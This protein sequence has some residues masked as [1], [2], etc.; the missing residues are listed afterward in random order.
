MTGEPIPDETARVVVERYVNPRKAEW[1]EAEYVV[2]NPPFLGKLYVASE[3]GDGYAAALRNAYEGTV[4][5]GSD[6]VL[7]WWQK[8]A[9]LVRGGLLQRFGLVTTNSVTQTMNRRILAN[10]LAADPPMHLAYAV[11]D[12]PW[13]EAEGGA[14]V[15]IAM[16][17]GAPGE[18]SGRLAVV[19]AEGAP[20]GFD[21]A[22]PVVLRER[23][24][25]IQE[26][27]T[28]G[29]DV[30][31]AGPLAANAALASMGPMLGSRGFTVEGGERDRLVR[32]DGDDAV[33]RIRPLRNGKDLVAS[34]RGLYVIDM[35]GL[36]ESELRTRFPATYQWLLGR[37]YPERAQ[38][39]DAKL[40]EQWWLFR[41]ANSLWRSMLQG[42]PRHIVTVETAKHRVFFFL[43]SD[44]IGEHGTISFG[45]DRAEYL[46]ILSSRPHVVWALATGGTL[47]DRPRYNKSVCFDPFP[48]PT[49]DAAQT[50]RI[51]SL[52]E[53][54]DAH[55]KRQQALHPG[56]TITGMY[57]VL[58][59]LRSGEALTA[60]EKVIHEEGLVSVLKQIH[61]DLDA[62]VFEAYGWPSTL[63]DEEILERLVALNAERAEEEKR[64][65]VRWLRPEFQNP[66]GTKAATQ[67]ALPAGDDE[68]EEPAAK[69]AAPLAWPKALPERIAAVRDLMARAPSPRS[70]A[71]VASAFAKAK[72]KDVEAVLDSLASLGLLV[73]FDAPDGRHWQ[74]ASA[75][76]A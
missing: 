24:G 22:I 15:R 5:D 34:P 58:E 37:V 68:D 25:R 72:P 40:R 70:L 31:S 29:P 45:L 54:L 64:G 48:F 21:D 65:L 39:R 17:V 49:T 2:G 13:V 62:A 4:P 50:A 7:Y 26:N 10:A 32:S 66:G 20:E 74:A 52:G 55:R 23:I 51:R 69:P 30:P 28:I 57:N 53:A 14:A 16:T 36:D 6:L 1:P 11:P 76:R 12:H 59:K 33:A 63:T 75:P 18:G 44:V 71:S 3:L 8:A 9:A 38:N 41:R 47:E 46:G 60:K 67:E 43:D 61:V 56:L 35:A 27:L 73:S 19:V 42:L